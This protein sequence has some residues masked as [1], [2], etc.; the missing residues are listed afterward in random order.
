M[1]KSKNVNVHSEWLDKLA[2]Q[3]KDGGFDVRCALALTFYSGELVGEKSGQPSPRSVE[4][5]PLKDGVWG[6]LRELSQENKDVADLMIMVNELSK[7]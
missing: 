1:K 4:V 5:S 7:V 6:R 2:E 3:V